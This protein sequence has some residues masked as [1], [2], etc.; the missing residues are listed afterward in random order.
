MTRV[1]KSCRTYS[2]STLSEC[3]SDSNRIKLDAL[4]EISRNP[5]ETSKAVD[6][7]DNAM[8][9]HDQQQESLLIQMAYLVIR[10][11]MEAAQGQLR[12]ERMAE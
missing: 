3:T 12:E 11:A 10:A 9:G 1:L 5:L 2:V 6:F 4:A 8:K 7:E